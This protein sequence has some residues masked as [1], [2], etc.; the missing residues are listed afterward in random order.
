[1][2][3][4]PIPKGYDIRL[5]A[6]GVAVVTNPKGVQYT[7]DIWADILGTCTCHNFVFGGRKHNGRCK[8]LVW[9]VQ[10]YPCPDCGARMEMEETGRYYECPDKHCRHCVGYDRRLVDIE[11][12]SKREAKVA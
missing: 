7:T 5:S 4:L 9:V 8:H 6:D 3:Y 2:P 11:R 1:M 10:S 12:H